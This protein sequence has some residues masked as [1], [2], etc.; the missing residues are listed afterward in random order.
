MFKKKS[1]PDAPREMAWDEKS[2]AH[3]RVPHAGSWTRQEVTARRDL[4]IEQK[5]ATKVLRRG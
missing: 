4:L 1:N 2:L 3:F 5:Q